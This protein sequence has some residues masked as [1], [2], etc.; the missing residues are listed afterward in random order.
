MPVT[1]ASL[2]RSEYETNPCWPLTDPWSWEIASHIIMKI[3]MSVRKKE[4]RY[5]FPLQK[6]H[7][8]A[9]VLK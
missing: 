4:S 6:K 7:I 1:K 3:Y 5:Y 2:S 9:G 8:D